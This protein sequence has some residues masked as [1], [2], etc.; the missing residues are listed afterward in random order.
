MSQDSLFQQIHTDV[1]QERNEP[2]MNIAKGLL[3]GHDKALVDEFYSAL[4]KVQDSA[5][6]LTS[7]MVEDRLKHALRYWLLALFSFEE[8]RRCANFLR[9][10]RVIGEL[11]A[12][13]KIPMRLIDF[14]IAHIKQQFFRLL[15]DREHRRRDAIQVL[16]FIQR[17][18]DLAAMVFND[19]YLQRS[20][21]Q[22]R[23]EQNLRH[24][25]ISHNLAIEFEQSRAN[26]LHW[27]REI[28][29][30]LYHPYSQERHRHI[31]PLRLSKFGLWVEHRA[32]LLFYNRTEVAKFQRKLDK[33][34]QALQSVVRMNQQGNW[35]ALADGIDNMNHLISSADWLL[36]RIAR[37]II[38]LENNKDALTRL[39]TRRYLPNII[40]HEIRYCLSHNTQLGVIMIDIDHFKRVND[41]YGHGA[42]DA[43]LSHAAN[44]LSS[45]LRAYDYI[46]R[47][48][49]EEF[50]VIANNS[51]ENSCLTIAENLRQKVEQNISAEMP[52]IEEPVTISLGVAIFDQHPD[53]EQLIDRAD[54]A[55]YRAKEKGRNRVEIYRPEFESVDELPA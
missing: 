37:E 16:N 8:N 21:Q 50:L 42:G 17:A 51:D 27:Y 29:T 32:S 12:R 6:F 13:I 48:G 20:I 2:L 14:G 43:V 44:L 23:I 45:S 46:F 7:D 24:Y 35:E 25:Y 49:G 9:R 1:Y 52:F 41:R 4:S 18:I 5:G 55:L 15:S 3:I 40:Q 54:K 53:Y 33:I 30:L 26:L 47:Y 10:Q 19:V 11:H 39:F 31:V 38:S 34:D 28:I 36:E 22:E